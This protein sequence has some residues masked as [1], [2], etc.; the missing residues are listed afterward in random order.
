MTRDELI[1]RRNRMSLK[2]TP[3]LRETASNYKRGDTVR[4]KE[5]G[6]VLVVR[7]NM[8]PTFVPP[9]VLSD[10]KMYFPDEVEPHA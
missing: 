3:L 6:R 5:T 7:N 9:L 8:A 4:V 2:R 1:D 10:N